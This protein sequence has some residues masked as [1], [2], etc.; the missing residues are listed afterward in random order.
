MSWEQNLQDVKF[1]ITTGDG[2]KWF[3]LWKTGEK[4]RE[5]NVSSFNFIDVEGT[6]VERKK[7]QSGK[8]PLVFWFQGDDN[9]QQAATFDASAADNRP[10]TLVHPLYGTITGQPLSIRFND[11]FHNITEITVDFWESISTDYPKQ[12][13]SVKDNTFEKKSEVMQSCATSY[14][15]S[16][17][18]K[19]QDV[20]KNK[21]SNTVVASKFNSLQTNETNPAYQNAIA[22]SN[23]AN[24]KLVSNPLAAIQSC[25]TLL[26]LPSVYEVAILERLEAFKAAF[27][28]FVKDLLTIADK[29]FFESQVGALIASICNAAVN[30]I[31]S[32]YKIATDVEKVSSTLIEIYSQYLRMLDDASVSQYD[33]NNAWQPDASI[34]SMLNDLVFYTLGNLFDFGFDSQQERIVRT[35]KDTNLILLTHRYLGSATDENIETFRII[36]NIKLNELLR[37]KKGREIKYYV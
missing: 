12:N 34:Q 32:D 30:P 2:K 14:A 21:E 27:E 7:P 24:D 11:E 15:T 8:F 9:V 10:W 33:I 3:P 35:E 23:S 16:D 13:F 36:N 28:T 5:Y 37:I 1:E 26:D 20:I 18:L 31:E 19:S 22:T 25:Q 4:S 29:L 17:S 6:L